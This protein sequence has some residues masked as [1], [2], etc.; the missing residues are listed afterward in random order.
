M[1]SNIPVCGELDVLGNVELAAVLKWPSLQ[2]A[3]A[4]RLRADAP[5]GPERHRKHERQVIETAAALTAIKRE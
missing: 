4:S 3:G 1:P 2:G 5:R